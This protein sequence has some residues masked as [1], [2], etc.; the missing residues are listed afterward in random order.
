M[1]VTV[2]AEAE[3]RGQI[4]EIVR[5]FEARV[6]NVGHDQMMISLSG[7]PGRLDDLLALLRPF[8][9]DNIQRTGVIA[10]RQID[11]E[12]PAGT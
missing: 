7:S 5:I 12:P 8:G 1:L 11:K 9:I 2:H 4:M 3:R 6:L 10:L